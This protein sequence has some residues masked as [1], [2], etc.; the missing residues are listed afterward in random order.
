MPARPGSSKPVVPPKAVRVTLPGDRGSIEVAYNAVTPC[1][2]PGS[3]STI[4]VRP[5]EP[6]VLPSGKPWSRLP[7]TARVLTTQG[8][9]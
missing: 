4:G 8:R 9:R 6:E 1:F 7:L 2:E 3:P 5:F